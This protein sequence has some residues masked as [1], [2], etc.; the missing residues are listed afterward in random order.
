MSIFEILFTQPIFNIL[1]FLYGI[2]PGHDLG[3]AV[4]IF[5]ILVRLALWP[6]VKKQLH[7]SKLMRE[8]QPQLAAIKKKA[9]G[10]RQLE[11]QLMLELYK[12]KGVNPFSSF[13]LLLIQLPFFIALYSSINILA[14]H[15]DDIDKYI[16]PALQAIPHLKEVAANPDK[17]NEIAFGFLDLT[18]SVVNAK[19]ALI[20]GVLLLI[21]I[22]TAILQYFQSKQLMPAPAEKKRLRDMFRDQS[23]GK[24]VDQSEMMAAVGQK[25]ILFLPVII[26][27]TSIYIAGALSLYLLTTTLVGFI[28]QRRVLNRDTEEMETQAD[29]ADV[30]VTIKPAEVDGTEK[31]AKKDKT[32]KSARARKAKAAKIVGK[33]R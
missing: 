26:F 2:V 6:L 11:G 12:E 14:N 20:A 17:F 21:A 9:K 30:K 13:G 23:N 4:I 7:Q 31:A 10:N 29:R 24:D 1:L 28:Q 3:I 27:I 16:Y 5:T 18:Q 19:T 33:K 25:T 32:S 15:K 22:V 8:L